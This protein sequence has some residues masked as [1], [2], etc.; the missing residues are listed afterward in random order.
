MLCYATG[1][2]MQDIIIMKYLTSLSQAMRLF[3]TVP[4]G[5]MYHTLALVQE[6]IV[7]SIIHLDSVFRW[8]S[9]DK[10]GPFPLAGGGKMPI[11][12]SGMRGILDC[13]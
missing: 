5:L 6:L 13:T 4:T 10:V 11:Y 12:V 9:P 3:I 8:P 7:S 2:V 1:F